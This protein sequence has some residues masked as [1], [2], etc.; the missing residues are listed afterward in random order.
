MLLHSLHIKA[1]LNVIAI[2]TTYPQPTEDG[3]L[4]RSDK[5]PI[6]DLGLGIYD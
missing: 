1:E 3:V 5:T 6:V 2:A 4:R